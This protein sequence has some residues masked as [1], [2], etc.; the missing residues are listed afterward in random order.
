MERVGA[1]A[2]IFNELGEIL[3]VHHTYGMCNWELPGGG[4]EAGE[5]P[6]ETAVRE[7]REETGLGVVPE[8]VT[9]WYYDPTADRLHTV[10]RCQANSDEWVLCPDGVEISEC[11]F[12][13][14]DNLPL[15]HSDFTRLRVHDALAAQANPLPTV[16]GPRQW[17]C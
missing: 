11:G 6:A 10:V 7:V 12:W 9:G 14:T 4:G 8:R 5:S 16:I 1:A 17:H 3:L 2:A 13:P 15:P